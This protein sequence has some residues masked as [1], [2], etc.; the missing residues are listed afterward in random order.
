M[1][2]VRLI[3][4]N[5]RAPVRDN[6]SARLTF[7]NLGAGYFPT[8]GL[9]LS[10]VVHIIAFIITYFFASFPVAP[11]KQ[12]HP[13][14][15][16]VMIDLNDPMSMMYLP[17]FEGGRPEASRGR[18]IIDR[19]LR[20]SRREQASEPV[21]EPSA[22]TQGF[23]YPGPQTIVSDVPEPTNRFQTLLQ[24]GLEN[25]PV[26]PPPITLPN[27]MQVADASKANRMEVP[28][29][30]PPEPEPTP[31]PE[32]KAI[33]EPVKPEPKPEPK[34]A[35]KAVETPKPTPPPAPTPKP[36][37]KPPEPAPKLADLLKPEPKPPEPAPIPAELPKP[38]PKPPVTEAKVVEVPKPQPK[39]PESTAKA[40]EAPKTEPK[41]SAPAVKPAETIRQEVK[42]PESAKKTEAPKPEPK[43]ES[44]PAQTQPPASSASAEPSADNPSGTSEINGTPGSTRDILAIS[45]MPANPNQPAKIPAGE[46]R[47]RFI[48][49]PQANLSGS[50]SEPGVKTGTPSPEIGIGNSKDAPAKRS[51]APKL[52][53]PTAS[54]KEPG[55]G[56]AVPKSK[57]TSEATNAAAGATRGSGNG[58]ASGSG[59]GAKTT[60]A[61]VKKPFAG[62]TIM[63][64]EFEPGSDSD[65]P[66]VT[67]AVRPLQTAYGLSVISTED[68]GGGLPFY[69]VFSHE[70]IYTVY[71]D[72][73]TVETDQDP[74]WTLEFAVNSDS[75]STTAGRDQQGLV[76]PFP[77]V[78][79]R[80]AWPPAVARKYHGRMMIVYGVVSTAGKMEQISVKESPDPQLN[81]P[82]I[83]ALSKWIFRPATLLGQTVTAKALLGIP[84]WSPE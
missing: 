8:R 38:A 83:R 46:A 23:S 43:P 30:D 25:P 82:I 80:P 49:S 32:Q 50:D 60:S 33:S 65:A 22:T 74:S 44:K 45:P 13:R 53:P 77:S 62:I 11:P 54:K 15:N 41:P 12:N 55:Q 51:V 2:I 79:E 75:S 81:E 31:Q 39:P 1:P 57:T 9:P 17:M 69:G 61:P 58:S 42:P 36:E 18:R 35:P 66:P 72:M 67:Q 21:A 56:S 26:L 14:P 24:P 73:R 48:I 20:P 10:I 76:L 29:D 16:I 47:G 70:Q 3:L 4:Q 5:G 84:I 7:T 28:P 64:G 37:P 34:P 19:I 71:L 27:I 68:S 40:A 59:S 52:A 78:K 6:P 63:G